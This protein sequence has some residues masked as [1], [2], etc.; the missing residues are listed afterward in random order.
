MT[1]RVG[2]KDLDFLLAA[3]TIQTQV[4]GSMAGLFDMVAD[5][6][7]QRQQFAR[8]IKGLT[9]MGRASAYVLIGLPFFV[10]LALTLLNPSYMHPLYATSTGHT[11]IMV[12]LMM[13]AFGSLILRKLVSF[14]G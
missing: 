3:I 11:L 2:S 12:G 5:T 13:M 10:A 1:E 9:A 8:K 4:G 7:R 14:K 6:V